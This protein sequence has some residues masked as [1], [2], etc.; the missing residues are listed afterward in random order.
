MTMF[1]PCLG[2]DGEGDSHENFRKCSH[3]RNYR[4]VKEA[5]VLSLA[6]VFHHQ[7]MTINKKLINS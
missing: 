1:A 4:Q 2:S 6:T 7:G 3:L 5:K